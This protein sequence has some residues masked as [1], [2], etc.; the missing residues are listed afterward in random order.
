MV[1][2]V[3]PRTLRRRALA[4]SAPIVVVLL[5]VAARLLSLGPINASAQGLVDDAPAEAA[6]RFGLLGPLNFAETWIEPFNVGVAR[7]GDEE[8]TA[9]EANFH[10]ALDRSPGGTVECRVRH[11]LAIS[12]EAQGDLAA[13][14]GVPA[15]ARALWT[16]AL[17]VVTAADCV[18]GDSEVSQRLR[19]DEQRLLDKLNPDGSDDGEDDEDGQDPGEGDDGSDP[20]SP[21]DP[22]TQSNLEELER[23]ASEAVEQ[24]RQD[25][26]FDR[27]D[28]DFS[29]GDRW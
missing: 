27:R 26:A 13:S 11:N 6:D 10:V 4:W 18:D 22:E 25:S 7:Y 2:A 12:I 9:A 28:T 17:E 23:R 5:V 1:V 15:D 19:E 16:D 29:G 24:D 8:F 21:P 3:T 20:P 14:D